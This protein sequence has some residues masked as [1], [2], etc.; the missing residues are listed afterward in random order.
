MS[1]FHVVHVDEVLDECGLLGDVGLSPWHRNLPPHLHADSP[2]PSE[3]FIH[4]RWRVKARGA[5]GTRRKAEM[6]KG[7]G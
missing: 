3:H 6:A 1:V 2:R 4:R 5:S 7:R